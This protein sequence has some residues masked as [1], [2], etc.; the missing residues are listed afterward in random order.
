MWFMCSMYCDYFIF[1]ILSKLSVQGKYQISRE[2][3]RY[4]QGING[5]RLATLQ[6]CHHKLEGGLLSDSQDRHLN[7]E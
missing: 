4:V 7:L 2:F 6:E 5:F 1:F 3:G